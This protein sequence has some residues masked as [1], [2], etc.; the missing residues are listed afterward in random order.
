MAGRS[1]RALAWTEILPRSQKAPLSRQVALSS[2]LS[3]AIRSPAALDRCALQD[4]QVLESVTYGNVLVLDGI[5]QCT[6]RDEASYSEM[7]AHVPLCSLKVKKGSVCW[8][9]DRPDYV[10]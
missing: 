9:I 4:V 7:M 2:H 10:M 3:S 5:I 1:K 8:L 6:E